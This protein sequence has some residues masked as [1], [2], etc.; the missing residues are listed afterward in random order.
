MKYEVNYIKV[1]WHNKKKQN[2]KAITE[3]KIHN[4]CT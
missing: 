4:P 2:L 1:I 3:K